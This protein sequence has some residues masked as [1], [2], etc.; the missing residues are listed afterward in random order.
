MLYEA[1]KQRNPLRWKGPTRNWKRV[2][3]VHLNPDQIDNF[4]PIKRD[5]RQEQKAA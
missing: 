3:T 5:H 1:A 2:K 4:E